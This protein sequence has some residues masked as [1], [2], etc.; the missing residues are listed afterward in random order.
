MIIFHLFLIFFSLG[1]NGRCVLKI[2][3]DED[4]QIQPQHMYDFFTP[5]HEDVT[6]TSHLLKLI[7]SFRWRPLLDA[8]FTKEI[9]QWLHEPP[10]SIKRSNAIYPPS[11]IFIGLAS[12]HMLE[13]E[14]AEEYER[15]LE[16]KIKPILNQM[17][18]IKTRSS[19]GRR[20]A[21][22]W[23]SQLPT[24]DYWAKNDDNNADIFREKMHKY[25]L[26]AQQVLRYV[27]FKNILNTKINLIV[28]TL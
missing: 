4:R 28:E 5:A 1:S 2:I 18:E 21:V 7:V 3:P 9:S 26:I 10:V 27:K 16:E 22:I 8:N 24:V 23:S 20:Q 25:N 19:I 11:F 15:V 14:A 13:W 6:V 12:H 17:L